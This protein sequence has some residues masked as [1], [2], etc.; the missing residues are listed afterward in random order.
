[1]RF[2]CWLSLLA[3]QHCSVCV[4]R[5]DKQT[6]KG[7]GCSPSFEPC[8]KQDFALLRSGVVP[9]GVLCG[10]FL[11]MGIASFHGNQ[12]FARFTLFFTDPKLRTEAV[13][14]DY[15]DIPFKEIAKF[16][17]IQL[18]FLAVIFVVTKTP[19]ALSFPVGIVLLVPVRRCFLPI[20]LP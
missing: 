10:L 16:T 15:I 11:F 19:A 7:D 14:D 4:E 17:L 1:M 2:L 5:K 3:A 6:R 12:L 20:T 13:S 18:F 9:I 8:S